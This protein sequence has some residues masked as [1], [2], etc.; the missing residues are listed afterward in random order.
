VIGAGKLGSI[1]V[2]ILAFVMMLRLGTSPLVV[3]KRII[4][5]SGIMSM[6]HCLSA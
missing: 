5:L 3:R 2:Y 6:N 4:V 1:K